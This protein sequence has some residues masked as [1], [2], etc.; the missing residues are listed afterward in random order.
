M[1]LE[2][3]T[4]RCLFELAIKHQFLYELQIAAHISEM[5][6]LLTAI[7]KVQQQDTLK[8]KATSSNCP[9]TQCFKA[10]ITCL[11]IRIITEMTLSFIVGECVNSA[12]VTF[13]TIF[14]KSSLND[15]TCLAYASYKTRRNLYL[16]HLHKLT[17][18]T[19][20]TVKQRA[21]DFNQLPPR[22]FQD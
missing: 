2:T 21:D 18:R 1:L 12:S 8:Y 7:C 10:T 19:F 9:R 15:S 14:T 11:P 3:Q 20:S 5:D 22:P 17:L 16:T 4:L 6:L 13:T